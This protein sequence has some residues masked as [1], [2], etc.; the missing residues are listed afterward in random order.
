MRRPRFSI[1]G[2]MAAV[3]VAGVGLAALRSASPL[4][5]RLVFTAALAAV[6]LAA[7]AALVAGGRR[8]AF[9]A[10]FV[11]FGGGALLLHFG[12]WCRAEVRPYLA[13]TALLDAVRP[14]IRPAAPELVEW[15]YVDSWVEPLQPVANTWIPIL[16]APDDSVIPSGAGNPSYTV[17]LSWPR[18]R[19]I[20]VE[21]DAPFLRIGDSLLALAWGGVG[22]LVGRRLHATRDLRGG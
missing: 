15:A 10:G 9:A 16:T 20:L 13:T 1:G 17:N 3:L 11:L 22:G 4:W 8:R 19:L 5:G 12:P 18:P 2:L 7:L 6:G 14:L 21:P